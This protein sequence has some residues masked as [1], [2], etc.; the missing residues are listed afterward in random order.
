MPDPLSNWRKCVLP[1]QD[2]QDDRVS[3]ALFAV[4]LSRAINREGA[5]E[6]RDPTLFFERT[7]L[8]LDA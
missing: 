5:P 3:E 6:Y 7:H 2:I 1:H 8:T 4:N